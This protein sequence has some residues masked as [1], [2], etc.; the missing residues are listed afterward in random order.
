MRPFI[1]RKLHIAKRALQYTDKYEE[2]RPAEPVFE[3]LQNKDVTSSIGLTAQK[4]RN[5]NPVIAGGR[6][7][8]FVVM[9]HRRAD[10][11]LCCGRCFGRVASH[12]TDQ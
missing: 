12:A 11:A 1:G 2:K 10:A 5:F 8:V 7:V 4:C 9:L 6:R 3:V